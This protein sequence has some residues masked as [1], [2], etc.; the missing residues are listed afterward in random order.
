MQDFSTLKD[1]FDTYYDHVRKV[2]CELVERCQEY[3]FAENNGS[4]ANYG[5]WLQ[6]FFRSLAGRKAAQAQR[7]GSAV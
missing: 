3:D 4:A 1:R 7:K 5:G 2:T 6:R